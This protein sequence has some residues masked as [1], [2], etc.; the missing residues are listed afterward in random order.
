MSGA[1]DQNE[2]RVTLGHRMIADQIPRASVRT[3]A[4]FRLLPTLSVGIEYN[5]RAEDVGPLLNWVALTETD[6]RPA[7]IAGT[8]SDRIGTP[9]GRSYYATVSKS[10]HETLHLPV[11]PYSVKVSLFAQKTKITFPLWL[12]ATTGDMS[13]FG[14][15]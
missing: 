3:T 9:S 14:L 5:P 15:L 8:S 1:L 13:H 12:N 6:S 2:G 7:V 11:A 10:L 4:M